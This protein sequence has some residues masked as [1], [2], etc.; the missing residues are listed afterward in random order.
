[1]DV[2]FY[3]DRG[4][5][6]PSF[7][8][9]HAVGGAE[10]HLVQIAEYLSKEGHDVSAYLNG[11]PEIIEGG[12]IYRPFNGPWSK[13]AKSLII[14][15]C[16]NIPDNVRADKIF[17]F[18]VVDPRPCAHMFDHLK[19]RAT[20]VCVSNWQAGLFR[21]LG[22]N[23]LVIPVPIPDEWY[24]MAR[25][26][27]MNRFV[28][29]SSWNKGALETIKAWKREWGELAVGSAYS[30]P[31]DAE[32]ICATYGATWLGTLRPRE[33]WIDA[34][35]SGYA[36]ARICTIGETFGVADIAARA[37]GMQSYTYCTGD[38]GSLEE[39]GSWPMT[40]YSR[41][42]YNIAGHFNLPCP[43]DPNEFRAS[44][45]LPMWKGLVG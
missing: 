24:G 14:V 2:V 5:F 26:P 27:V 40:A 7:N 25:T 36:A 16:A 43:R 30:H 10:M 15:G 17:A 34:L 42:A 12:V 20:M 45:V 6:G 11:V 31:D 9:D 4:G 22:H 28:C 33:R 1:V 21:A 35:A 32:D 29:V 37:M 44:R 3:D 13:R 23:T 19:G 39:V 38:V 41:W 8:R 18:Q